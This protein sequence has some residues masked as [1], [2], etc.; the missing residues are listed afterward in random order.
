L[1]Q[2]EVSFRPQRPQQAN[3]IR[4]DDLKGIQNDAR[5]AIEELASDRCNNKCHQLAGAPLLAFLA[6]GGRVITGS[7]RRR[8]LST[9]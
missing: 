8:I 1:A 7:Q 3:L 2:F 6:T 5:V 9:A 4:Y